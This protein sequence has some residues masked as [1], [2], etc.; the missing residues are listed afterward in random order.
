ML[1]NLVQGPT[2]LNY[3]KASIYMMQVSIKA[4]RCRCRLYAQKL[5]ATI[6]KC[7]TKGDVVIRVGRFTNSSTLMNFIHDVL[8]SWTFNIFVFGVVV[9]RKCVAPYTLLACAVQANNQ[10]LCVTLIL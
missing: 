10:Y 6:F 4:W 9:S 7:E 5:Y 8:S 2:K 3:F 1:T